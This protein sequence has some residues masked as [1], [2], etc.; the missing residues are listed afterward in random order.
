MNNGVWSATITLPHTGTNGIWVKAFPSDDDCNMYV[1]DRVLEYEPHQTGC[2]A[3]VD[4]D[5][6]TVHFAHPLLSDATI[7]IYDTTTNT[8]VGQGF[9]PATNNPT[10]T[11]TDAWLVQPTPGATIL[12]KIHY[13]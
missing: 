2:H 8:L 3:L 9:A 4:C 13:M 12:F 11:V 7:Y 1:L 5:G 6:W 10:T